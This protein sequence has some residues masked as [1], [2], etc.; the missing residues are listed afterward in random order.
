MSLARHILV[1]EDS[2]EDFETILDAAKHACL[3]Y[4]TRRATTGD[5]GLRLLR[6][7]A[8]CTNT[9]P[10]LVL[11]DLNTPKDGH[12]LREIKQ[13]DQLRAIPL[14]VLSTSANPIDLAFCYTSGANAYHV[15]PVDHAVH[16]Q[17]LQQIF[18]YW[19]TRVVLPK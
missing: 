6:E 17:V 18:S 3:T 12:A 14:I 9:T 2:D 1:V 5:E 16:L 13:D 7:S 15:K 10:A 11:L 19:L 4:E 8:Q